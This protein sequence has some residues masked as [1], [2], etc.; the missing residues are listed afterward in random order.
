MVQTCGSQSGTLGK[1]CWPILGGDSGMEENSVSRE[2]SEEG[3]AFPP[4]PPR[5]GLGEGM[6]CACA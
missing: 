4:D 2:A 1:P 3:M 6:P 5:L